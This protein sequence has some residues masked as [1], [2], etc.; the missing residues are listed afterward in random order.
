MARIYSNYG[1]NYKT[2]T[3]TL[4]LMCP[5]FFF[6]LNDD[7]IIFNDENDFVVSSLADSF[8]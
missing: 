6:E 5:H 8:L 4:T 3:Q 1:F 2:V 7:N